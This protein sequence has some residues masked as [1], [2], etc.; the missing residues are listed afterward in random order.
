MEAHTNIFRNATRMK[1]VGTTC[2]GNQIN[3]TSIRADYDRWFDSIFLHENGW[4]HIG[5]FI[6]KFG[7]HVM[8]NRHCINTIE[9][10]C[11]AIGS[12]DFGV[13]S[14]IPVL[15]LDG[16]FY[17]T[18]YNCKWVKRK[19]TERIQSECWKITEN[20]VRLPTKNKWKTYLKFNLCSIFTSEI[21]ILIDIIT[22][23]VF[24]KNHFEKNPLSVEPKRHN[25][26][27]E[28]SKICLLII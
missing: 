18:L 2:I 21:F 12:V 4:F 3:S 28:Q 9:N 1:L 13:S 6:E 7:S 22:K 26:N 23:I 15:V 5:D 11:F 20:I 24:K 19:I 14:F 8:I 10:Y 27:N 17:G 16:I 25:T